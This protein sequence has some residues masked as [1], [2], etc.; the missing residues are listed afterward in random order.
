MQCAVRTRERAERCDGDGGQAGGTGGGGGGGGGRGAAL[1]APHALRDLVGEVEEALALGLGELIDLLHGEPVLLL[2]VGLGRPDL[3]AG[4]ARGS[5]RQGR[6][7][8][9]GRSAARGG[10][11]EGGVTVCSPIPAFDRAN[12]E[13]C[14]DS[15]QAQAGQLRNSRHRCRNRA[16]E[17]RA[18]QMHPPSRRPRC[19]PSRRGRGPRSSRSGP[20]SSW[21]APF[22]RCLRAWTPG[23]GREDVHDALGAPGAG[24]RPWIRRIRD[25]TASLSHRCTRTIRCGGPFRTSLLFHDCCV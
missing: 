14:G 22:S 9:G 11:V 6:G 25:M 23:A 17:R 1:T 4:G 21:R 10:E 12:T 3:R 20:R 18:Q 13:C 7:V 5:P 2:L 24:G 16:V 19:A 8:R 15:C